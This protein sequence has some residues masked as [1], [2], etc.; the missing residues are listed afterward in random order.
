MERPR[1]FAICF[2]IFGCN[3]RNNAVYYMIF[4]NN[5]RGNVMALGERIKTLRESKHMSQKE[6]ATLVGFTTGTVAE[7]EAN[8]A[9]P[10]IAALAKLSKALSVSS[11]V[12]LEE[13]TEENCL[14]QPVANGSE[15]LGKAS[16]KGR[17]KW[18]WIG[19]LAVICLCGVVVAVL[20]LLDNSTPFSQDA[21]SIEA[22]DASVV[23][24]FC[25][26]YD[27]ELAATGSGFV[28]FNGKTVVTNYHVMASAYSCKISTN[29]DISYDVSG[30]LCYSKEKD[31]AILEIAKDT[32]LDALTLGD[33]TSVKKGDTV[34]AIG[35]PLGIKNTVSTGVLSGRLMEPGMDVLQFTAPI[36]SGSSG[37]ALFSDDGCVIGITYASVVNG[38]NLNLAIP[39]E[40]VDELYKNKG[41]QMVHVSEIY[42]VEHPYVELLEKYK[43]IK[44]VTIDELLDNP[45]KYDGETVKIT[46]YFSSFYSGV[47]GGTPFEHCYITSAAGVTGNGELDCN[48]YLA[49]GEFR[50]E[51]RSLKIFMHTVSDDR[52][53]LNA[54]IR[55]GDMVCVIGKVY[56]QVLSPIGEY[57]DF[58]TFSVSAA[59]IYSRD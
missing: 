18:L 41:E 8:E 53:Y 36:S 25:Y 57:P 45:E 21:A 17:R 56:Y 24:I 55:P 16:V 22:A 1:L 19:V 12:L 50:D 5:G 59:L 10:D 9:I 14:E 37:G 11:D 20:L 42:A 58:R 40:L 13:V 30:I 54:S 51:Y 23:T 39:I 47:A 3:Q 7:W 15:A 49:A 33:S 29:Q 35:S 32:G 38:Q 31:I 43:G 52:N 26:D 48:A 28:A 34:V 44:T 27:G 2:F 46:G 4:T 6:L